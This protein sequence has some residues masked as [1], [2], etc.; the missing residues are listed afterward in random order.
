MLYFSN[1]NRP[2]GFNGLLRR[3]QFLEAH[4]LASSILK[5]ANQLLVRLSANIRGVLD[6][7]YQL[8]KRQLIGMLIDIGSNKLVSG[9][10]FEAVQ[11]ACWVPF[12]IYMENVMDV[13]HLPVRSTIV[14]L[15][16]ES[17][18]KAHT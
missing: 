7:E 11:S 18:Y 9:C 8:N 16:G 4:K 3:I 12:D 1:W 13:K 2:E 6:F 17:S 5:S 14:I 15:R 10:N